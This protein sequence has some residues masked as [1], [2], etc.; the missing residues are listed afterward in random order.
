MNQLLSQHWKNM[1]QMLDFLS[2]HTMVASMC[3]LFLNLYD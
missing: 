3:L 2:K 1:L